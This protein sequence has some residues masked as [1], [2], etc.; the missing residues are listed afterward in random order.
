[1]GTISRQIT[2]YIVISVFL[3]LLSNSKGNPDDNEGPLKVG[4]EYR[5]KQ[6]DSHGSV[7]GSTGYIGSLTISGS[8]KQIKVVEDL[9]GGMYKVYLPKKGR[10]GDAGKIDGKQKYN[11]D[12][13]KTEIINVNQWPIIIPWND[14]RGKGATI[15]MTD[16]VSPVIG[17]SYE[18]N[19]YV[20]VGEASTEQEAIEKAMG[21][22]KMY[23]HNKK[24][25]FDVVES[26]SEKGVYK[27]MAKVTYKL[28]KKN[29]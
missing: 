25:S 3:G 7:S 27:W 26:L 11:Y 19:I 28:K 14:S 10:M 18:N 20:S 5:L 12:T 2:F 22:I 21:E 24:M 4:Y 23:A 29:P 1:M 9:G 8:E 13:T 6:G 15:K 17:D 16:A